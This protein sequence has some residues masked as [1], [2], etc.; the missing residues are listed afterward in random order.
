MSSYEDLTLG[1]TSYQEVGGE[2]FEENA[3]Q[4]GDGPHLKDSCKISSCK[5]S[6]LKLLNLIKA[7][8]IQS[9]A[10][11]YTQQHSG[12]QHQQVSWDILRSQGTHTEKA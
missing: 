5:S 8:L 11:T 3:V 4:E 10:F 9:T 2:E 1:N 12:T 6:I 7:N